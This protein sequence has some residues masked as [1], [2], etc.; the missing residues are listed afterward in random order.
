MGK[1]NSSHPFKEIEEL[2]SCASE[3]K[4]VC[5]NKRVSVSGREE[6][7]LLSKCKCLV[8]SPDC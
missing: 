7:C 5:V 3:A 2:L 6:D 1:S 4:C 8:M